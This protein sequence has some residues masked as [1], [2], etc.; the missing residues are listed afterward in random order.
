MQKDATYLSRNKIRIFDRNTKQ[1]IMPESIDW[2]SDEAVQYMFRQDPGKINAMGSVKINFPN[3]HAVYM[4]D[5]PQQSLFSKLL[6]FESSGCVRVQNPRQLATQVLG[7]S[8]EEIASTIAGRKNRPVQLD[9]KLPVH[10]TY[11]TAWTDDAGGLAY[12]PDVYERDM[13]LARAM[14]AEKNALR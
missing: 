7:W 5:T 3:P 6:R 11:F 9:K 1:E 4:H 2:N 10:L 8:Q 12:Y 13:Y 14:K